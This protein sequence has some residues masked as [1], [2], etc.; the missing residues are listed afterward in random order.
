MSNS[1]PGYIT[2]NANLLYEACEKYLVKIEFDGDQ[3]Y[4]NEVQKMDARIADY[5]AMTKWQKFWKG[6]YGY[7]PDE[8]YD[9]QLKYIRRISDDITERRKKEIFVIMKGAR[10]AMNNNG[11]VMLSLAHINLFQIKI[12][13]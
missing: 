1:P 9:T 11:T 3:D 7:I 10:V 8:R 6:S 13:I 12:D 4:L 2:V 5:K